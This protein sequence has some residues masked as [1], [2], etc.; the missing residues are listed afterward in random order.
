MNQFFREAL[1]FSL[2]LSGLTSVTCATAIASKV[3]VGT[4]AAQQNVQG[5]IAPTT[6]SELPFLSASGTSSEPVLQQN[7][8]SAADDPMQQDDPAQP[9]AQVN[10]VSQLSDVQPSDWAFQSLQSLVERYGCIAGYPNRTFRGNRALSRY[11]FAAGLNACL[12]RV[13]ELIAAGTSNLV[14]KE[15]I[16]ALRRLQQE[17]GPELA[18]IRGRVDSLEAQTAQ[19]EADQFST[20]TK[21]TGQAIFD[22]NGGSSTARNVRDPNTTFISRVRLNFNSSFTG[23]DQLFAQ[24]QMGQGSDVDN[25]GQYFAGLG[26]FSGLDFAN[27]SSSVRLR[28]L[29][30]NFP[31]FTKDLQVSVF[32]RGNIG[33]YVDLNSFAN[34]AALDFSASWAVNDY[35]VLGGDPTGAGVAFTYNPK[36][37]PLTFTAAYR[38]TNAS[39]PTPQGRFRNG[40]FDDPFLSAAEIAFSPIKSLTGRVLYTYGSDNGRRFSALGFNFEFL[41]TKKLAFFGRF[42]HA[43]NYAPSA[44][45]NSFADPGLI[46]GG[47]INSSARPNYWH[48]SKAGNSLRTVVGEKTTLSQGDL[49]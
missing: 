37:G 6:A 47:V 29:R 11:E 27:Q 10:S 14:R 15:D 19:L 42:G 1:L 7:T 17:F 13:N 31:L 44:I 25:A 32:A 28:R 2:L 49:K 39:N 30:Y 24:L 20:T 9:M 33:D 22:I 41:A 43:F 5:Q 26:T 34:D 36:Q 38:A 23:Q 35:L 46:S 16:A 48:G 21:L 8:D 40:V 3:P 45:A 18:S 4:K 12:D